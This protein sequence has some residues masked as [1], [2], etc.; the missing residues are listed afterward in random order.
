M[1]AA[2]LCAGM[3]VRSY[4]RQEALVLAHAC[5]GSDRGRFAIAWW[6]GRW[7]G[8][9]R[10][11]WV[12]GVAAVGPRPPM[13]SFEHTHSRV[14]GDHW[15]CW[16][17]PWTILLLLLAG[18]YV[19]HRRLRGAAPAGHCVRCGYDLRATPERCPECGAAATVVK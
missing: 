7:F 8:D 18:W 17:P 15:V 13:F 4:W 11:H 19:L 3:W 6:D 2:V 16:F 14:T 12:S 10:V 9:N 1:V 5:I